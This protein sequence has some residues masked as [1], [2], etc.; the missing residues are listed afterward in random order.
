MRILTTMAVSA[1]MVSAAFAASNKTLKNTSSVKV[2]ES[3][4]SKIK[5]NLGLA[6]Y[7][8]LDGPQLN[9]IN[10]ETTSNGSGNVGFYNH[11]DLTY[12]LSNGAKLWTRTAFQQYTDASDNKEATNG[13]SMLNPSVG[14]QKSIFKKGKL[15][16]FA[17]GYADIAAT[18]DSQAEGKSFRPGVLTV[19]GY[20]ASPDIS[21]VL[22]NQLRAWV[23]NQDNTNEGGRLLNILEAAYKINNNV[24][25]IG[26]YLSKYSQFDND[27][28]ANLHFSGSTYYLGTA[29]SITKNMSFLPALAADAQQSLTKPE[30]VSLYSEF[31]FTFF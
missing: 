28:V 27:E 15:S 22:V 26:R 16:L 12:K 19:L 1:L 9:D 8:E 20:A 11:F 18:S 30:N 7:N 31:S 25:L 5:K 17:R 10:A 23:D 6:Y 14:I 4:F 29:F 3:T 24:S 2:Q 13:F 21:F